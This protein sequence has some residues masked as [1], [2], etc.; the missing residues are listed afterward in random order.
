[1]RKFFYIAFVLLATSCSTTFYQVCTMESTLKHSDNAITHIDENCEIIYDF[2]GPSGNAGFVFH[3]KTDKEIIIDLSRSFFI[4]N[5]LAR[6]YDCDIAATPQKFILI[7]PARAARA[8]SGYKIG[9]NVYLCD[10]D[11]NFNAPKETSRVVNYTADTTPLTVENRIAYDIAGTEKHI[12]NTFYLSKVQNYAAREICNYS[13]VV[14]NATKLEKIVTSLK[15]S[16]PNKFY[17]TYNYT[18]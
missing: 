18:R 6:D 14:N 3:N 12:N 8:I 1:M 9:E 10:D 4:V 5:G 2:W 7:V 13:V 17:N 16:A 11:E 15:Y